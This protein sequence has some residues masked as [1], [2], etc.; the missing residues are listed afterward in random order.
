MLKYIILNTAVKY[1][2]GYETTS[3]HNEV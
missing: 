1:W 2:W 3:R